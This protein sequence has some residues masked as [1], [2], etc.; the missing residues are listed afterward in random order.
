L[1]SSR[2]GMNLWPGAASKSNWGTRG[3]SWRGRD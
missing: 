3:R 2:F 1:T